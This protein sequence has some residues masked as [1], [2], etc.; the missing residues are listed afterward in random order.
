MTFKDLFSSVKDQK[1]SKQFFQANVSCKKRK[2][3]FYFTTMKQLWNQ[4][5]ISK[6]T[7][8]YSILCFAGIVTDLPWTYLSIHNMWSHCSKSFSSFVFVVELNVK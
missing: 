6:L 4:K 8:L 7:D 1:K 3:E 5:N 2:K